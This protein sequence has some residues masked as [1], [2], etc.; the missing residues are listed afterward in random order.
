[1]KLSVKSAAH[2]IDGSVLKWLFNRKHGVVL[3][4]ESS[5]WRQVLKVY[6]KSHFW[7][8]FNSLLRLTAIDYC[9]NNL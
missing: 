7:A 5:D 6:V 1:M 4:G 9:V 2:G 8:H 3:N